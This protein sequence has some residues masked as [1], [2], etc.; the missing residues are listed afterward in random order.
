MTEA[1]E[2]DFSCDL[3]KNTYHNLLLGNISTK[4]NY[5][6]WGYENCVNYPFNS[7]LRWPELLDFAIIFEAFAMR[8]DVAAGLLAEFQVA[9]PVNQ[10][11]T[12]N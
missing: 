9:K 1:I 12:V 8:C 11:C 3:T 6:K 4:C 7:K 2:V 10:T 5:G